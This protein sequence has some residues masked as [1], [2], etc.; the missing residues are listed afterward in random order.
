MYQQQRQIMMPRMSDQIS[1]TRD[2]GANYH[3]G[4]A[5]GVAGW[6]LLVCY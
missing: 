1:R 3:H 2:N 6:V 5:E 4:K